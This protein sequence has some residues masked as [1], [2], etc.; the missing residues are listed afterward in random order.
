[1][2]FGR[3]KSNKRLSIANIENK[4]A[5]SRYFPTLEYDNKFMYSQK[6][7]VLKLLELYTIKDSVNCLKGKKQKILNYLIFIK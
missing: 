6:N 1:M 7:I 5:V 3:L 4:K 2:S